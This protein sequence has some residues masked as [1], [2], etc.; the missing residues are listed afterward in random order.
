[1]YS[2]FVEAELGQTPAPTQHDGEYGGG[3]EEGHLLEA[4]TQDEAGST[5][6]ILAQCEEAHSGKRESCALKLAR[7]LRPRMHAYQA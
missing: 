2:P 5:K 1:M 3:K 6:D 4:E 7:E